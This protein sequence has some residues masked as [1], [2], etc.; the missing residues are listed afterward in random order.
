MVTGDETHTCLPETATDEADDEMTVEMAV[1]EA[2][3][4]TEATVETVETVEIVVLD[5]TDEGLEAIEI[6][7]IDVEMTEMT[8]IEMVD[9]T[10]DE[11]TG[12]MC[13]IDDGLC[14]PTLDEAL[15]PLLPLPLLTLCGRR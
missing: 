4:A 6:G 13:L 1:T 11:T 9:G 8:E 14:L 10:D 5:G 12:M 3:E 7:M 2:E 15:L